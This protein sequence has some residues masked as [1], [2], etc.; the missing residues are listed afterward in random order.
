MLFMSSSK[1]GRYRF[2]N[3]LYIKITVTALIILL[4]IVIVYYAHFVLHSSTLFTHFFY[5]PIVLASFW[6]GRKGIWVSVFM[7]V[8]IIATHLFSAMNVLYIYNILRAVMFVIIAYII[9][10]LR[11]QSLNTQ[12]R[13]QDTK[14]YLNS[15]IQYSNTPIIVWDKQG[16]I[17]LFNPA[18]EKLTGYR[19]DQ[20]LGQSVLVLFPEE[21]REDFSQKLKKTLEGQS[22]EEEEVPI[23]CENGQHV[24]CLWSAATIFASDDKST[25]A[26]IAQGE[27]ITER[28]QPD[29][30][31]KKSHFELDQILETAA[32]GIWIIERDFTVIRVNDTMARI[33]GLK[34]EDI[35]GKK[36][37]EVL[38]LEF[39][40]TEKCPLTRI[41]SGENYVESETE[42]RR[43]DGSTIHCLEVSKPYLNPDGKLIGII[44]DFRDITEL[45]HLNGK[46]E[47]AKSYVENII[48]NFL[49]TLIVTNPD[50]TIRTINQATLD[51]LEYSKEELI[52]KPVGMIFAEEEEEEEVVKPFFT[53]TLEEL[54]KRGVLRN[55]EL[56]YVTKSGRR[57]PMSFNASVMR[58]E[59][60][61]IMGL[62]AGAKD[63]S[64]LKETEAQL[65]QSQKMEAIGQLAGGVAHDFNN[66]LTVILGYVDF[67][68]NTLKEDNPLYQYLKEVQKA[69]ERA[70][71]L[72]SQLL[73]FSRQQ[74]MKMEPLNINSV[75]QDL[76]RML[77]PLIGEDIALNIT[78]EPNI[79]TVRAN[80][81]SIEQVIMNLIVN[82]RDAMPDGGKIL[83]KTENIHV[84]EEYCKKYTYARPG[85]FI[86]LSLQD[87]GIGMTQDVKEKIFDPFFT[88]KGTGKGTGMGLSV[89]YGIVKKHEGW[90]NVESSPGEGAI[91]RIYLPAASVKQEK[92]K[93]VSVS[94]EEELI[95]RGER[96]LLVE[97]DES[98]RNFSIRMLSENGYRVFVAADSREA[99]D[100]FK[101]EKGHFDL[102]LSDVILPDESGPVLA[103]KLLK[104]KPELRFLFVSGYDDEKMDSRII[105]EGGYP[106]LNKPY[107]L[108]DLLKAMKKA[109]KK[110]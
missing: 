55:Y 58:N 46:L 14:N 6:W 21:Y 76:S 50:G 40:R 66:M 90:I 32:D 60:G 68:L 80:A 106:F 42:V 33:V 95:G 23:R 3:N 104:I 27:D 63:I 83:I 48:A 44:D 24:I 91:F 9:G 97:D 71:K 26:N 15:L 43:V 88:T 36:C 30:M 31:I 81:S 70:A 28:K 1:T 67:A 59:K 78:L 94:F 47:T 89:I 77:E 22:W 100:I 16:K 19:A 105:K 87:T 62:V 79:W 51:L 17:T 85:R 69:A 20:M 41:L 38:R 96:I 75:I 93:E 108:P 5:I 82:A 39:C 74:T 12:R 109:M 7:G 13:L 73:L 65:R 102:I 35:V 64:K 2:S 53:G 84:D 11:E 110:K 37:Y 34:K 57:I 52:G 61:E 29:E 103:N 49:D 25:I 10:T 8:L 4:C 86:L 99:I 72:T 107:L 56:T 45:K 98:L 92:K 54:T 101:K 18:F